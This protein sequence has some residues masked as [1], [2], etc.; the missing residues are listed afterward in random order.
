MA[1]SKMS[2]A[3]EHT[4]GKKET[5]SVSRVNPEASGEALLNLAN[6]FMSLQDASVKTL[7]S[8]KRIDTTELM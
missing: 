2:Y 8:V 6:E 5:R 3:Y 4:D 1:E 7:V